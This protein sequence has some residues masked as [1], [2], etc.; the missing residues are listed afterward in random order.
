VEKRRHRREE[1]DNRRSSEEGIGERHK[2]RHR[3]SAVVEGSRSKRESYDET[4]RHKNDN[5]AGG[6]VS[7]SYEFGRPSNMSGPRRQIVD[8]GSLGKRFRQPDRPGMTGF[9]PK[10]G[11]SRLGRKSLSILAYSWTSEQ[12]I[13]GNPLYRMEDDSTMSRTRQVE[14]AMSSVEEQRQR[15]G[16]LAKV[17][18]VTKWL[19]RFLKRSDNT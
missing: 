13:T 4:K 18:K 9:N 1:R 5:F 15:T 19:Q 10:S 7:Q 6:Q 8:E 17:A 12:T 16:L 11:S 3:A 14:P 2:H